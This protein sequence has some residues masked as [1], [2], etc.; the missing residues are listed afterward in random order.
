MSTF[1]SLVSGSLSQNQGKNIKKKRKNKSYTTITHRKG[2]ATTYDSLARGA[3][4]AAS[5]LWQQNETETEPKDVSSCLGFPPRYARGRYVVAQILASRLG[6]QTRVS[7]GSGRCLLN[8]AT[9]IIPAF[10]AW[11]ANAVLGLF[12]SCPFPARSF[13][14]D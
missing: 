12:E 6:T 13:Q 3:E 9:W 7:N 1:F 5:L 11:G 10:H 2:G 14:C 8:G 4:L